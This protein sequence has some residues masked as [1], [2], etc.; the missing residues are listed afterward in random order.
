MFLFHIYWNSFPCLSL[1]HSRPSLK[2]RLKLCLNFVLVQVVCMVFAS[3]NNGCSHIYIY[4]VLLLVKPIFKQFSCWFP[5]L[6]SKHVF[7]SI[8]KKKKSQKKKKKSQKKQVYFYF[9]FRSVLLWENS[10]SIFKEMNLEKWVDFLLVLF[11]LYT[12]TC[13]KFRQMLPFTKCI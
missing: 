13:L 2:Y 9:A 8:R 1:W 6:I 11:E 10:L 5:N 7:F 12:I 4:I 3:K